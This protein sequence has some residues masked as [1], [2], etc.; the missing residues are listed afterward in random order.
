MEPSP[1]KRSVVR[2]G[3]V[4]ISPGQ[5]FPKAVVAHRTFL[6]VFGSNVLRGET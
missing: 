3:S 4:P 5:S 1:D 6:A 2:V